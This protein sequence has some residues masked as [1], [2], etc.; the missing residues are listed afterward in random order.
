VESWLA[1]LRRAGYAVAGVF[2]DISIEESVRRCEAEHRR[3]HDDYRNGVGYGG[4]YVRPEAIRALAITA[5]ALTHAQAEAP[6][7]AVPPLGSG[8]GGHA[9]GV[10]FPGGEVTG[11]IA[12][13]RAGQ[14][15]L[16]DLAL[17]FRARRWPVVP[18]ACPPGM[19]QAGPV[20]DDPEPYGPGSF[21]DVVL[22]Y[23][24]GQLTDADYAVLASAA[25]I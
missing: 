25:A 7:S 1:V 13:Y 17:E 2:A 19:E 21:D 23:D 18:S 3:R 8:P 15:S 9:A 24:L 16:G 5:N 11:M 6:S 20:I 22:A 14:L 10:S 4:R 12:A